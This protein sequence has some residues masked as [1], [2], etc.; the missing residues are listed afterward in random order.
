[1]RWGKEWILEKFEIQAKDLPYYSNM[2]G[3]TENLGEEV[4]V[5]E[6]VIGRL[7]HQG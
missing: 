3:T 4:T 7:I 5:S 6:F 1:M 2:E